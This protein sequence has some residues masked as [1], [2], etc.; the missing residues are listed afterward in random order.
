MPYLSP[1]I[2]TMRTKPDAVK[3]R[4]AVLIAFIIT[5][6][7]FFIWLSTLQIDTSAP[8]AAPAENTG[9]VTEAGNFLE[10]QWARVK[11]GGQSIFN[12]LERRVIV[13]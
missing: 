10:Q 11:L 9:P 6:I 12:L 5:F 4:L 8:V 13:K 3:Q 2:E 7:I 1:Y